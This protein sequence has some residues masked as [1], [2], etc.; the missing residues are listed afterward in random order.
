MGIQEVVFGRVWGKEIL[1]KGSLGSGQLHNDSSSGIAKWLEELT[2]D[3]C[4]NLGN[5][6]W[7]N[8]FLEMLSARTTNL[9][10]RGCKA[11][12]LELAMG[13]STHLLRRSL[14]SFG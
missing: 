13:A 1:F 2:L 6:L 11:S 4:G 10:G 14:A 9:S 12:A 7:N 3:R 8:K 5:E